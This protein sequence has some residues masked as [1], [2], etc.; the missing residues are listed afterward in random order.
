MATT[1]VK[2]PDPY[3]APQ[4]R[5]VASAFPL[6]PTDDCVGQDPRVLGCGPSGPVGK[7]L[8]SWGAE[9]R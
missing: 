9:P 6:L 4:S 3:D 1:S 8:G 7:T 5:G 2:R